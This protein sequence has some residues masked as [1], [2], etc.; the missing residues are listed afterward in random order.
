MSGFDLYVILVAVLGALA[1]NRVI[2]QA[3]AWKDDPP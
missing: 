2:E 3:S 1:A